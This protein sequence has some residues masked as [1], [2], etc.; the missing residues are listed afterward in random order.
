MRI[1]PVLLGIIGALT[2][3]SCALSASPKRTSQTYVL[4]HG[5]LLGEFSWNRVERRLVANGHTVITLDLP[6]HG[7]DQTP[8]EQL[9]LNGY[10]DAVVK[11][12]GDQTNVVL[13]GHS[14]GGMV[15]SQVAEAIPSKIS[16][17]VYLAALIPQSG[18]SAND[19]AGRDK[20]SLFGKY[21]MPTPTAL[22]FSPDGL[23]P[24]FCNDCSADD[25]VMLRA[26]LRPEPLA[27][28]ATPVTLT[29]A[30]YGSVRK[31]D[32]LTKQ[33]R[34]VSYA[35]QKTLQARLNFVK[36]VELDTGHLPFFSRPDEL[37]KVLE[38]L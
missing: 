25:V 7:A 29:A 33:D 31:Y 1:S 32:V 27:P 17:L 18:E 13:V 4:V 14:F 28:F 20:D 19:L 36:S 23:G 22:V 5:A 21:V 15:V 3:S 24:V 2:L 35:F 6:G 37:A 8:V 34:A 9:S 38:G 26:K 16:K 30:N 11:A 12:I 10:R